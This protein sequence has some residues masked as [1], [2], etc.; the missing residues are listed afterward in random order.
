VQTFDM[1][2]S[3]DTEAGYAGICA[4]GSDLLFDRHMSEEI[5]DTFVGR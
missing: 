2:G 1:T 4:E 3:R 5:R